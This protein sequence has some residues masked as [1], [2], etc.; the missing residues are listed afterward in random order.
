K[1]LLGLPL[2]SAP[3]VTYY[4]ADILE[5]YGYPSDPAEL[6]EFMKDEN[7]WLEMGK[8]LA[9]DGI[10]IVQ[11]AGEIIR[12]ST[13]NMPYFNEKLEYQR[14]NKEFEN[15]ISI[16]KKASFSGLSPFTDIWAEKGDKMLKEDKF[17]MLYLGSWGARDLEARVPEQSGKW[18][19]TSLPFGVYG[20]NNASILSM[21]ENSKNKDAAWKFMEFYNFKYNTSDNVGNVA[22]Y[23]PFRNDTAKIS[24]KNEFLGGQEEQQLYEEIMAKTKEYSVTPLDDKAFKLWDKL[25]NAGIDEDQTTQQI[26]DNI[27]SAINTDFIKEK[28]IIL[29]GKKN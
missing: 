18:R 12:I 5:K 1:E 27:R 7:N 17:A 19:A 3:L 21:A 16:A 25:V 29:K 11:W 24:N 2:A 28:E 6:A 9:A 22:G 14:D 20:W 15:A 13:S 8:K 26:M 4:R 10:S 23:L